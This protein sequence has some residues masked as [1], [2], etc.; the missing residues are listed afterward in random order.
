MDDMGPE[1][2]DPLA[3]READ[4]LEEFV[5]EGQRRRQLTLDAVIRFA[6][7]TARVSHN[8]AI[9]AQ[10]SARA[11]QLRAPREGSHSTGR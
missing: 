7:T 11:A 8:P 10:A 6:E 2:G 1:V 3:N 9:S 5:T 4:E